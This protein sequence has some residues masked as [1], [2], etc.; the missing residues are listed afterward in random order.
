MTTPIPV[1]RP[2]LLGNE[3]EYVLDALDR[4]QLS[5][6]A[7]LERF[8][9]AFAD[10]MGARHAIAVS[11]GTAALHLALLA[12]G[13]GPGDEVIVPDL[14]FIATANAVAYCGATPVLV[15]VRPGDWTLDVAEVRDAI[16]LRTKAIIVVHLYGAPAQMDDLRALADLHGLALI[17][18]AAEALGSRWK[19][20]RVGGVGLAGCFSF[21]GNKTLSTGEG[22][23]VVTQSDALARQ[24]RLLRGQGLAPE[25][26]YRHAAL[27]YNYRLSELQAAVGLAQLEKVKEHIARRAAVRSWYEFRFAGSAWRLQDACQRGYTAFWMNVA[28]APDAETRGR[29]RSRLAA[30]DIET[31]PV[32]V[33]LH[34]QPMYRH[35]GGFP[36]SDRLWQTG[37]VLPT[38]GGM[39]EEQVDLICRA[40]LS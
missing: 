31:R 35:E 15:D 27:G 12:A 11:S 10:W 25:G 2:I 17:E 7:Y 37:I 24:V 23:M 9:A 26:E 34:R 14:T 19:G 13:V 33:P 29:V 3:W 36:V 18:D 30:L 21:Y 20:W 1:A 6:G 39:N 4:Y 28:L 40:V 16:A 22:G 32:F 8:E 5:G 38:H